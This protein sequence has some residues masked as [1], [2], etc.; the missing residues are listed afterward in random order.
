MFFDC[1]CYEKI[2]VAAWANH[3][4]DLRQL[5]EAAAK[6]VWLSTTFENLMEQQWRVYTLGDE[7]Q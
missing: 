6:P 4:A 7:S 2:F 3:K 1:L 5:D